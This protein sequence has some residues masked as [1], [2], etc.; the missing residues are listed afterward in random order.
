MELQATFDRPLVRTR[1]ASTRYA[2]LEIAAPALQIRRPRQPL[3]L[4][5]VLDRSGSMAGAKLALARDAA[6]L[7]IRQLQDEDRVAIIAYDDEV[8]VVAPSRKATPAAKA[9]LERLIRGIHSGGSTNLSGGWLEGCREVAE[10]QGH[11][12]I[13]RVLLL[14]DGLANVGIVDQE[15][16]CTHAAELRQRGVSTTTFGM[17]D[18]YNEDLL[19]AMAD[20]GG[21]N[22]YYLRSADDLAPAFSQ[23]L[24]GLLEIVAREVVVELRAPG[25][26]L[27]ILNDIPSEPIPD[28]VR[29]RIGDLCSREQKSLVAKVTSTPAAAGTTA[30]LQA[31]LMYREPDLER[32]R[33]QAFPALELRHASDGEV[34]AQRHVFAVQKATGLLYAARAKQEAIRLNREGRYD[35]AQ[36]VLARTAERI[37]SYAG[38]D[39]EL[40]EAIRSL[41]ELH[42]H[43]AVAMAAPMMKETTFA[44]YRMSRMRSDY[45]RS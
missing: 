36:R 25:A 7:L 6:A 42:Q 27:S 28:G 44:A 20:K 24:G 26:A 15:Q 22:Y 9:D 43:A 3:N 8:S 10:K 32:G 4:A 30:P 21:G 5:L 19:Q 11:G 34:D 35:E 29:V 40:A 18:D 23:E 1:A 41:R 39:E 33:E 31:V 14:T 37:A 12:T 38:S 2:L 17:G 16:L 13:D 45:R